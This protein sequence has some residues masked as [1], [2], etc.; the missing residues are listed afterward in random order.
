MKFNLET[1]EHNLISHYGPGSISVN[2]VAYTQ[3]I[4]IYKNTI[5]EDW[6]AGEIETLT[7]AHF[8]SV[9][10]DTTAEQPE[11]MLLGTGTAHHFPAMQL[12]AE[13]RQC[14]VALEVMNTRAA[15]RTYS[16]LMSEHRQVAAALLQLDQ[17]I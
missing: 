10:T 7:R 3:N 6:F 5:I 8:A 17:E 15:C 1:S 16:V 12:I 11:I 2:G 9:L 13:L 4:M 14:G